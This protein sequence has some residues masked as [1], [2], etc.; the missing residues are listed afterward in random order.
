MNAKTQAHR[1]R[2][3]KPAAKAQLHPNLAFRRAAVILLTPETILQ[4]EDLA[5]HLA[6]H[7]QQGAA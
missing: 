7:N 5:E 1:P 3:A 6:N 2:L 4:I